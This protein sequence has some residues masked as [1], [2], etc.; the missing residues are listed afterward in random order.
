MDFWNTLQLAPT[1]DIRAIK[2]AYAVLL[3]QNRP[4]D[5]PAGFQRLHGAYQD[6]LSWAENRLDEED[7]A[8]RAGAQ[9]TTPA[10]TAP[11][12]GENPDVSAFV[13]DVDTRTESS[14]AANATEDTGYGCGDPN[15]EHCAAEAAWEKYLD[16]QWETLVQKVEDTLEDASRRNDPAAWHFLVESEALLDI[17]F[18][19]AFAM[20]FLQRLL[21]LFSQQQETGEQ[22]LEPAIVRHL[23]QLFWWSERRH[24]YDDYID[25]DWV[26]DFMQWWLVPQTGP[27]V[28]VSSILTPPQPQVVPSTPASPPAP[29]IPYGNYYTRW[30]AML[31]DSAGLFLIGALA[32]I[33]AIPA[34]PFQLTG[35]L[36]VA[37]GYP[38]ASA[39]FEMSPLQATPG[40]LWCKLKVCDYQ[41]QR[42]GPFRALYR[43]LLFALSLYFIY[44]TVIVNL[45]ISDG[46]LVHDRMSGSM[47]LKR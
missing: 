27:A 7:A 4:D 45:L 13:E 31:I 15:C 29:P 14:D 19:G 8:A 38:L 34:L 35:L 16:E 30:V 2:K 24:H 22:L 40:K 36:A 3:K 33:A 10:T 32:G 11:V 6:A 39:L 42:L 26:D 28:P 20:R 5:N 46:R 21:Q 9:P 17:D 41:R 23:N 1:T 25:P 47:V 37:W 12:Q 43:S 44:I 18:K